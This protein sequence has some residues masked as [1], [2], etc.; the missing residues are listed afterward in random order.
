MDILQNQLFSVFSLCIFPEKAYWG[1]EDEVKSLDLMNVFPLMPPCYL[2]IYFWVEACLA[3]CGILVPHQ[4]LNQGP[5]QWK[6][7]VLTV[8][9]PGNSSLLFL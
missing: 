5:W 9:L 6:C 3:A 7:G 2:F 1:E 4:G 8:G